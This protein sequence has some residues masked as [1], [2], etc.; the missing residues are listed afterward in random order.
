[1]PVRIKSK[2]RLQGSVTPSALNTETDI[3]NLADQSDDYIVEGQIS[4]QNMASDDTVVIRTYIAVDGVNRKKA[5]EMT[6]TGAQDIPVVRIP[7]LTLAYNA[8]FR[9]T[10][11]Q[12]AG[13]TL[14]A[15]P[16]TIICQEME[17][18]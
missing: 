8:K 5:D 9:A 15:F 6:F 10:I 13:T 3:V 14:K 12:T 18:I 1:M 11:T 7:A 17:V 2:T 4:L 16:Y